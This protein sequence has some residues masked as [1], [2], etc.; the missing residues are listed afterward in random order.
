M[1]RSFGVRIFFQ[2]ALQ[3]DLDV[4]LGHGLA[5]LPMN[6]GARATLEQRAEKEK[7][8]GEVGTG[9]I[10]V[11]GL[12][13]CELLHKT[14]AFDRGSDRRISFYFARG[15]QLNKGQGPHCRPL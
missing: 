12:V 4:G 14:A 2:A 9:D 6:N 15:A 10:D 11:Q 5:Q 1:I 13:G 7:N 8:P 3:D